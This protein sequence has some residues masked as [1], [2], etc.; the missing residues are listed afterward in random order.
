MDKIAKA[1]LNAMKCPIC[2]NQIDLLDWA[3]PVSKRGNNFGCVNDCT[4]YSMYFVHWDQPVRIATENVIVFDGNRLYDITQEHYLGVIPF[5]STKILVR[6]ID[7]ENRII[8]GGNFSTF[9]Y[10][11]KL[12][13]F[14]K[15]DKDKIIHR[16]RTILVF[17]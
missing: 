16:V 17:Q 8:D 7:K 12:F 1:M 11:K 6:E 9:Q 5:P 2:G 15:T 10:D 14:G 4:H 13:D 3:L